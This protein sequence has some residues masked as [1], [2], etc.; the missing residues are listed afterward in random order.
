M[1]SVESHKHY[2]KSLIAFSLVFLVLML[3]LTQ[4]GGVLRQIKDITTTTLPDFLPEFYEKIV[5]INTQKIVVEFEETQNKTKIDDTLKDWDKKSE[6]EK[7]EVV[8]EFF[9]D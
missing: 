9:Y 7:E 4:A 5:T 8:D 6:A 2:I 3:S 1:D